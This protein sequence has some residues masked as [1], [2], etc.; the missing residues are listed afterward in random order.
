MD[1]SQYGLDPLNS[2][3]AIIDSDLDGWDKDKDGFITEDVTIGTSQWGES[4]SNY[5][6]YYVD[7]DQNSGVIPGVRGLRFLQIQRI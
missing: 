5:E 4:F 3:D 2:S 1:G 6:E 7:F